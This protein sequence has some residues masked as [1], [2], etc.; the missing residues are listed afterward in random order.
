MPDLMCPR[1]RVPLL[2]ERLLDQST[3]R[4][5]QCGGIW[6]DPTELAAIARQSIAAP[7]PVGAEATPLV[8][9]CPRC[10]EP[11][12]PFVYA[13]DS[14][15]AIGRCDRCG[16]NWLAAGQLQ[17]VVNYRHRSLAATAAMGAGKQHLSG[18]PQSWR[19]ARRRLR[20]RWLSGCVA[21]AGV[22]AI[23]WLDGSLRLLL[24]LVVASLA[25]LACIWF[26]DAIGMRRHSL[27]PLRLG[28]GIDQPTVGDLV[29]IGGW[30]L[31]LAGVLAAALL[32]TG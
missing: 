21:A 23:L 32:V 4:C 2:P 16:G 19:I 18:S 9:G 27:F 3:D 17:A 8:G 26:S 30:V 6:V 12:Q 11:L 5:G 20:S 28:P 10:H 22:A 29:A 31:M 13:H 15:I 1:C 24:L 25:P 14:G 7:V